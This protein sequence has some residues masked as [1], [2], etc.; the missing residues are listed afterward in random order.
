MNIAKS[1]LL[2]QQTALQVVSNNVANANTEGYIRQETVLDESVSVQTGSLNLGTGV[3]AAKVIA[4]YDKFLE[5]SV[6]KENNAT[7][8]ATTYESYFSR[9][10]SILN[11]DNTSLTTNIADFFNAWQTLSTDPTSDVARTN[12]VTTGENMCDSI[13]T[14]YSELK[15]LQTEVDS[16]VA[17]QINEINNI[18][19]SLADVNDQ[20]YKQGEEGKDDASLIA[21]KTQLLKNL[22]GIT[23]IQYFEDDNGGVTV[24]TSGGKLLVS[25]VSVNELSAEKSAED[26]CYRVIWGSDSG[27]SVD[28]TD[29]FQGGSLKA[30]IDL[31]D[32]E[33]PQF[34]DTIN[35]LAVSLATEVNNAH[36]TGYTAN[37]V[38]GI[39]FFKDIPTTGDYAAIIAISDEVD[40]S[41]DYIATTSSADSTT[42]ND[43]ALA[44]ADLG[45][46]SI[47]ID[48]QSITYT[49]YTASIEAQIG[50]LSQNAQELSEYHQNLLATVEAQRDSVSGVSIDE[51]MTN[52][53]KFQTAYQAAARLLNTADT[54][55][56]TLMEAFQ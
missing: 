46:N 14:I 29:S 27:N 56:T 18:L 55:F 39:N 42:A 50:S 8:E 44:I 37:G 10:E 11:E 7:E 43:I 36:S 16:N 24:M 32:N 6:A 3:T 4:C 41:T 1:A 12:V 17:E 20:I 54:L 28:I 40:T 21:Q 52:L 38:T 19:N 33:I 34:M 51:E 49:D 48:G 9:I 47:T 2:A 15:N 31:R 22:S 26:D 23:D 53:I 5:A 13:R 35:D 25:G 30:L 45:S